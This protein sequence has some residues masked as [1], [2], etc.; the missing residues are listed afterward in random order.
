MAQSTSSVCGP[1]GKC[2]VH[3]VGS[4]DTGPL[5]GLGG[6]DAEFGSPAASLGLSG[7]DV[8]TMRKNPTTRNNRCNEWLPK[9]SMSL[10]RKSG[11]GL[12]LRY[13]G[14]EG[15]CEGVGQDG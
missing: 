15:G 9:N 12:G 8:T 11:Q 3:S 4:S 10:P 5:G 2:P 1:L 13:K 14:E 6:R 7:S